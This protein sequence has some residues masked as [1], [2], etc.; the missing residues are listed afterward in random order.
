[1]TG[2]AWFGFSV[3]VEVA[4]GAD[5][6][7]DPTTWVWTDITDDVR[8]DPGFSMSLG[9]ADEASTTQP[10]SC[11]FVVNNTSGDYSLGGQSAN[12]PNVRRN[13][14]VRVRVDPDG[15][16]F[17]TVFT[18]GAVGFTPDW[19][20]SG[21]IAIVKV[22]AAGALRR[23][24][25]GDPP[26]HS[27]LYRGLSTG[28]TTGVVAYWPC[29]DGKASSKFESAVGGAP[30]QWTALASDP[31]L[32]SNTTFLGSDPLPVM[33]GSYWTAPIGAVA[34]TGE[35]QVRALVE[36]PDDDTAEARGVIWELHTSGTAYRWALEYIPGS[37]GLLNVAVF[38]T[39][40]GL[41]TESG[42]IVTEVN[43]DRRAR[44]YSL[45]MTQ[46][47]SNVDVALKSIDVTGHIRSYTFTV[48]AV[49][50]GSAL[51]IDI[52]GDGQANDVGALDQVAI[53][54][55][56]VQN[57]VTSTADAAN[58]MSGWTDEY[59]DT[60]IERLC[61][62]N[63]ETIDI[64][65]QTA[66]K[67]GPQ[68]SGTLVGLLRDCE[69][70]DRGILYDGRS[71]GL[72]YVCR[73]DIEN[74]PAA[75]TLDA[76]A[77]QLAPSFQPVDDDQRT[78]NKAVV[79][80]TRGT[81]A[82]VTDS[83]GPMG[84]DEIG[85]YEVSETVNVNVDERTLDHAGWRVHLGT[86][87]GY[88]YPTVSVDLRKNPTL[89]RDWLGLHP[90]SRVDITNLSSALTAHETGTVSLFVEG[91]AQSLGAARWIGTLK[92]SPYPPWNVG[93][94]GTGV[95]SPISFVGAGTAASASSG[96]ITPSIPSLTEAGDLMLLFASTRNS[97]TGTVDT[98]TGYTVLASSGNVSILGK[99]A[100]T[101]EHNPT[102]T[103]T[104]GAANETT[105]AQMCAFRGTARDID[106]VLLNSA[107]LLNSS[108][109]NIGY[110]ALT[111]AEDNCAVIVAGW[112]QDDWTSV[113]ALAGMTEIEEQTI[114][115]GSDAGQVWDYVIQSTHANI[116][117]SSF[118][119]TGGASAIS[120]GICLALRPHPDPNA[121]T[122][123]LDTSG[124]T[125]TTTFAQGAT[126]MSVTTTDAGT[127]SY[128]NIGAVAVGNNA[129]VVPALPTG[130]AAGDLLLIAASIRNSGTGTVNTPAGWTA[131]VTTG[132]FTLLGQFGE[133]DST[134]PTVSFTGG[135]ANETTIAQCF[136]FR[137]TYKTIAGVIGAS[138]T[139]LNGSAQNL[140]YPALTVPQDNCAVVVLGWKQDD[141]TTA[142]QLTGFTEISDSPTTTGN[143]AG[144]VIDYVI[145]TTL[146]NVSASSITITGG[147]SAISRAIVVAIKP[148]PGTPWT[149]ATADYPM[150]L[151]VG[152]V[153]ITATACTDAVSPQAMTISAASLG[154]SAGAAVKLWRPPVLEL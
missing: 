113:A 68:I 78:V 127:I 40:G 18:G 80:R 148:H 14:P 3:A 99:I 112:K 152:G 81:T 130:W 92:C 31:D 141:W 90:G 94:L 9:R 1:M 105:I 77:G 71:S 82:T 98:P 23:L 42:G 114:T 89:A 32:A 120:R 64:P 123:R 101:L 39:L 109:A 116:S 117:A 8:Q 147:A 45:A 19:D 25:Q 128:V 75:L 70:V 154:R 52:N 6:M 4:W 47:G 35:L 62:E 60:R 91:I 16:G 66:A 21:N 5:L 44:R 124:S 67:M 140:A 149:T 28:T 136:A 135:A 144:L 58:E 49:T 61:D 126:S 146:A 145:Q 121:V 125:L 73:E 93:Q 118:T 100:T 102:V 38:N 134:A 133:S 34:G 110:P 104:G 96:S 55:I 139:Q 50:I 36:F 22:S 108:A 30:L 43:N 85:T 132:N 103:F 63:G 11:D 129:S 115:A 74:A 97:G 151:D 111:V 51:R 57:D 150:D 7:A 37:G 13:T 48:N 137:G 138:A 153:K 84:T 2:Q 119:V 107:T 88:R 27:A 79:T 15:A 26:S 86:W 69:G 33:R 142:T 20:V 106:S 95:A 53:G 17:V 10:A 29:E 41:I 72:S 59:V 24:G 87:E 143:D 83:T 46:N 76:S 131:L 122:E 65:G 12:W 54:H 56:T